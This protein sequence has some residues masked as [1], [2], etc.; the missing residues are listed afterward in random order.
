MINNVLK[1]IYLFLSWELPKL[2]KHYPI[3]TTHS[4]GILIFQT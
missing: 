3:V 1:Y 4:H 2:P